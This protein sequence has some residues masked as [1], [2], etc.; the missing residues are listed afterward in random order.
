MNTQKH[1][2][3]E[4]LEALGGVPVTGHVS[5]E[6]TKIIQDLVAMYENEVGALRSKHNA[7]LNRAKDFIHRLPTTQQ[8]KRN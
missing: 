2:S 4:G 8:T 1:A 3:D 5:S 7:V 6:V